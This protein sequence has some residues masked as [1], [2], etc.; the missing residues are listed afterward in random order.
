M[1]RP[2]RSSALT[3]REP[4]VRGQALGYAVHVH[5]PSS[6]ESMMTAITTAP[7][8]LATR[9]GKSSGQARAKEYQGLT[10]VRQVHEASLVV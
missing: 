3:L 10:H 1:I 9:C 8:T 2:S 7:A 5:E 4:G 6:A